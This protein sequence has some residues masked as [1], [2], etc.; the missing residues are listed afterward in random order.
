[1]SDESVIEK[2]IYVLEEAEHSV[3]SLACAG[4]KRVE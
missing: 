2:V 1:M 3:K 4:W